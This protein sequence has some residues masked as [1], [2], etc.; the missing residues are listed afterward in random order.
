MVN[1]FQLFVRKI[2]VKGLYSYVVGFNG[3][4]ICFNYM[5]YS[6]YPNNEK[7]DGCNK[8]ESDVVHSKITSKLFMEKPMDGL[9]ETKCYDQLPTNGYCFEN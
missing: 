7:N 8:V 5:R 9:V 2:F 4:E 1:F 6:I 3:T